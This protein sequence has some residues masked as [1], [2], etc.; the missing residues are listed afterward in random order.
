MKTTALTRIAIVLTLSGAPSALADEFDTA[1]FGLRF[2]SSLFRLSTYPDVVAKTGAASA[3]TENTSFNPAVLDWV[4]RS[5]R[6]P[7]EQEFNDRAHIGLSGQAVSVNFQNNTRMFI[8]AQSLLFY[9]RIAPVRVSFIQIRSNEEPMRGQSE[10]VGKIFEYDLNAYRIEAARRFGTETDPSRLSIGL[11]LSYNQ[12][13]T[14]LIQPETSFIVPLK[15]P[16][17][18]VRVTS[19]RT[20][21]VS[22]NRDTFNARFGWQV[23]LW[24][25]P[26][27][28]VT[29]SKR[30]GVLN[31]DRLLWGTVVD[32]SHY[33]SKQEMFQPFRGERESGVV[34]APAIE[35]VL[36]SDNFL[37]AHLSQ[38]TSQSV[39][40]RTGLA[41]KWRREDDDWLSDGKSEPEYQFKRGAGWLNVDYQWSWFEDEVSQLQEHRLHAGV[42]IPFGKLLVVSGGVSVDD[43]RNLSWGVGLKLHGLT[44]PSCV[45]G[46][47][48]MDGFLATLAYQHDPLPELGS[49]FGHGHLWAFALGFAF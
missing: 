12:A 23:A 17:G 32:Y 18:L 34:P 3:S 30:H 49:E 7:C 11:S 38:H 36:A 47:H 33:L 48:A 25:E 31:D 15:A 28:I 10:R 14:N 26:S 46:C 8:T 19:D 45:K 29:D 43:R 40:A 44:T 24:H 20:A 39:V 6:N 22:S 42:D 21:L 2:G 27:R 35:A 5:P 41:W 37:K 16:P 9:N 4:P 13:E 1:P